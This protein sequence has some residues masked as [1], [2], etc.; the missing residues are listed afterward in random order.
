MTIVQVI[1]LVY[2]FGPYEKYNHNVTTD[3]VRE[4]N[5]L[6][7][8]RGIVFDVRFDSNQFIAALERYQPKVIIGIGQHPQAR[9]IRIE[10]RARNWHES[11][12]YTGKPIESC[13]P[14]FRYASLKI[15]TTEETTVTY[16]AGAYVCNYSM[17]LMCR[18]AERMKAK[19]AFLHVPIHVDIQRIIEIFKTVLGR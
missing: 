13:G 3:I 17:Y 5:R 8:A 1:P 6:K 12:C 2:G 15:P 19:Y 14:E 4:V 11:A 9:K 7:L 10:R 16:N 18:E